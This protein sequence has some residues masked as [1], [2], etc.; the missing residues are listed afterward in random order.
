ML[1]NDRPDLERDFGISSQ[2][3]LN[4]FSDLSTPSKTKVD[5]R[6]G[7]KLGGKTGKQDGAELC[8]AHGKL[9]R[10]WH[11]LAPCLL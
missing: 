1:Q 2:K 9:N 4:E 8:Q 5:D 7:E 10:F 6:G 3:L 11:G